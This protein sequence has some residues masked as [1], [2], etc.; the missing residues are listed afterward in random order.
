PTSNAQF[1]RFPAPARSSAM[2]KAR[3]KDDGARRRDPLPAVLRSVPARIDHEP[4]TSAK[5]GSV[6]SKCRLPTPTG[7]TGS[8][9]CTRDA[10]RSRRLSAMPRKGF[11][12]RSTPN[13]LREHQHDYFVMSLP[14]IEAKITS[15][16][17]VDRHAIVKG[18]LLCD[19]LLDAL[20]DYCILS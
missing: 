20:S 13:H 18:F 9:P 15:A 16:E 17:F 3:R 4:P 1:Q 12:A 10:D 6:V 11:G 5:S 2:T 14:A 19:R 7:N 8:T